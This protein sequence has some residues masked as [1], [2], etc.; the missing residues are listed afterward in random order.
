MPGTRDLTG[1]I[2]AHIA[3]HRLEPGDRLPAERR[4]AE[5]LGVSRPALREATRRLID[6]GVLVSRRGS[7]TY[8]AGVDPRELLAVRRRLEPLAAELAACHASTA[9]R[10]ALGGLVERLRTAR[11]DAARFAELDLRLHARVARASG[12]HVLVRCLADL[13]QLLRLSRARTAGDP[14]TRERAL[15]DLE[16]LVAAIVAG[17]ATDAAAAMDAHLRAVG[18][19][20]ARA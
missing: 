3:D 8:V 19:A 18:A 20:V 17:R 11:D 6:L 13:D 4:L 7:G 1:A 5:A 10:E 2:R 16:R 12:N 9:D 15:A 14:A